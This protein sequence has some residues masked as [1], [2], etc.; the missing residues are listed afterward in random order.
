MDAAHAHVVPPRIYVVIFAV[1][2]VLTALTTAIA[3]VDLGVLNVVLMLG[4]AVLKATLVVL[5][6][7]HA[8]YAN[9]LTHVVIGAG[10]LFL[11]I[12]ISIAASDVWIRVWS[13]AALH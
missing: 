8:R 2:M 3:Y 13:P 9:Q 4:I 7:M 11:G 12:L 6:F 10:I 5:W 1:L